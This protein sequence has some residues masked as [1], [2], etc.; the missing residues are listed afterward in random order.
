M[1]YQTGARPLVRAL[2]EIE[3]TDV[4]VYRAIAASPTPHLDPAVQRLARAADRSLLWLSIA[5]VLAG[6]RGPTR[7]AAATGVVGIGIASTA[8]NVVAKSLLRRRRPDRVGA[9]VPVG[10]HVLM[11]TTP[12]FPSGHSA[13]AFAFASAV[14]NQLPA[15]S[16]PLHLLATAVAYSRVHT[17]VHYP[18]DTII[19]AAIGVAA[20]DIATRTTDQIARWRS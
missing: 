14:G 4:A 13:S 19:G 16:L 3:Q 20:A 17:G 18:A 1:N 10:R 6:R 12:S 7:R 9:G 5:A 15:A 11:P 2:H 8:V